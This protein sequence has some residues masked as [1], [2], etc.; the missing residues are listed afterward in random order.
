MVTTYSIIFTV[1]IDKV[2]NLYLFLV[3]MKKIILIFFILI[4]CLV[5][6]Q[7]Q[8]HYKEKR[9]T[10]RFTNG[11]AM[12]IGGVGLTTMGVCVRPLYHYVPA[13]YPQPTWVP[14]TLVP[15]NS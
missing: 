14:T 6:S 12:T 11:V 9:N 5:I 15:T 3:H 4:P 10:K 1:L 2:K 8:R 7:Y 13:P